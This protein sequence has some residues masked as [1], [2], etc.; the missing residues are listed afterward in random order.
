MKTFV[1]VVDQKSFTRAAASLNLSQPTVSSHI[2]NLERYF[3]AT[4]IDRSPKR[5]HL[6]KTG[7]I[8][9]QR[10]RQAIGLIDKAV[11]EVSEYQRELGGLIRIGASYTVGNTFF[12]LF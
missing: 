8:V 5:F 9:Y 1:A 2:K 6:T 3:D 4:L 12:R 7:E 11:Q 10:S